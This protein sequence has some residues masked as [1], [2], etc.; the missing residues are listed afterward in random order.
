MPRVTHATKE[1]SRDL[2]SAVIWNFVDLY[3]ASFGLENKPIGLA[4]VAKN[5]PVDRNALSR[6]HRNCN[7]DNA[8]L[9]SASVVKMELKILSFLD[10]V[11]LSASGGNPVKVSFKINGHSSGPFKAS[12]CKSFG[13][14]SNLSQIL[15]VKAPT[16]VPP[17]K[18]VTPLFLQST[19][20]GVMSVHALGESLFESGWTFKGQRSSCE[21]P[22]RRGFR[23]R[24]LFT[25]GSSH[26]NAALI[27]RLFEWY[28]V[29]D[30]DPR[31]L[32]QPKFVLHEL[33]TCE[34]TGLLNRSTHKWCG[35]GASGPQRMWD[36]M[37]KCQKGGRHSQG[38]NNGVH[39]CGDATD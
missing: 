23:C 34:T 17:S 16:P 11:A 36:S 3:A 25:S 10:S 29:K 7:T 32:G 30:T 13:S 8:T 15:T 21:V 28:I 9:K 1:T 4:G 2:R 20:G 35:T 38:T 27:N 6:Y 31:N 37:F 24:K 39:L 12:G 14:A 22:L 33:T 26:A 18:A 19:A 5:V